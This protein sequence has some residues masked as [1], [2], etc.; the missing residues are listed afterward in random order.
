M[1]AGQG[2]EIAIGIA[3]VIISVAV[4]WMLVSSASQ[5]INARK[6]DR[7]REQRS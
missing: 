3:C 1:L 5:G 4:V 6:A 7:Q 2:G